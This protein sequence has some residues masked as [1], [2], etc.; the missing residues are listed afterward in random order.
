MK[1][2]TSFTFFAVSAFMA[3]ILGGCGMAPVG[4]YNGFSS[5]PLTKIIVVK[6]PAPGGTPYPTQHEWKVVK[7]MADTCQLQINPQLSSPAETIGSASAV[8]GAA[9][10]L[11]IGLGAKAFP[12]SIFHRYF[13]YGGIAG[14]FSGGAYGLTLYSYNDVSVVGSCTRDFVRRAGLKDIYVYPAYIRAKHGANQVSKT[15]KVVLDNLPKK[16]QIILAPKSHNVAGAE[17][18]KHQQQSEDVLPIP[19]M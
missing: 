3:M 9:G 13:T 4:A 11:G 15:T 8:Y 17:S 6:Y 18:K 16:E 2:K 12:G 1:R 14:L 7:E 10:G 19:P 5:D